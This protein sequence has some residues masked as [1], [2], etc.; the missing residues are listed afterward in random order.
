MTITVILICRLVNVI[1]LIAKSEFKKWRY[2][3]T[4]FL[5]ND[6]NEKSM[7]KVDLFSSF[8][9]KYTD[10][11]TNGTVSCVSHNRLAG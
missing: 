2:A 9:R 1:S 10:I 6:S 3:N 7:L 8:H 4:H 11:W 5:D